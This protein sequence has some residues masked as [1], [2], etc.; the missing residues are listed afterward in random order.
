MTETKTRFRLASAALMNRRAP[1]SNSPSVM[2]RRELLRYLSLGALG[3]L[4]SPAL[5]RSADWLQEQLQHFEGQDVFTRIVNKA[6]AENWNRLPIG[7]LIGKIAL[8]LQGTP[9]VG[10]TLEASK[11]SEYCVV[12]LKGLDCVTFFE[13]ALCLARMIK[14]GK[15][16]AG[17]P[18][19]R[20]ANHALSRRQNGRLHHTAPL[21][22]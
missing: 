7:E 10:F 5:A 8:E 2:T 9:Y 4:A 20:S 13:D 12:N 22:H 11:D 17:G 21:H 16:L 1:A 15:S 14:R 6:S 3:L 18:H 19:R